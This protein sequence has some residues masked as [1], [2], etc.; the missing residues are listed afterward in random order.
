MGKSEV[1][2]VVVLGRRSGL[3]VA[4]EV[5]RARRARELRVGAAW[6][7]VRRSD[8]AAR[9]TSWSTWSAGCSLYPG[10]PLHPAPG[11][12][13]HVCV[14]VRCVRRWGVRPRVV[15]CALQTRPL[16]YQFPPLA[17]GAV[18]EGRERVERALPRHEHVLPRVERNS[19]ARKRRRAAR[20]CNIMMSPG[21][22]RT[23]IGAR[24]LSTFQE[25]CNIACAFYVSGV[26]QDC[27]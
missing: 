1:V 21:D 11:A 7:R 12:R 23:A 9:P 4:R 2:A 14:R 27:R 18:G 25:W 6:R 20:Q 16:P 10:T 13:E 15:K 24:A 8:P 5:L 17:L 19:C 22:A 3:A 26:V